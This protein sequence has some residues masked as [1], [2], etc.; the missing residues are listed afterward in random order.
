MA[1]QIIYGEE[2]RKALKSGVDQLAD[3]V[4]LTL[5]PRGRNVVLEKPFGS[6]LITNDG[7]TIA[8]DIELEDVFENMGAQIA[9]EV[10]V[11]TN[12]VA[13]DGTTTAAVLVQAIVSE[14]IKN[15]T[16]G[17]NP[18]LLRKGILDTATIAVEELKAISKPVVDKNDIASVAAISADDQEIG[19]LVS[20]AMEKVGKD[21]VIS[22]QEGQSLSTTLDVVEGMQ[23]DRGYV[24]GYMA[25]N[26]SKMI[27]EL[28]SPAILITDRKISTIQELLPIIEQ[29]VK[30]GLKLVII[31]DDFEQEVTATLVL[32][33]LKGV[34]NCVAVKAPGFGGRR[35]EMLEDIA[36]LTNGQ[37]ISEDI[38]LEVKDATINM[39]GRAKLVTVD[40]DNTTIIGGAGSQKDIE[41]RIAG[42]KEQIKNTTSSYDKE[43]LQERLAKLAGGVA[44][45]NVGAAT[46]IE[47]QEKKHRI[48][49][50]LA[51]TKAAV[52]E[53]TVPGGGV[54]LLT[55][56]ENV[57]K[58]TEKF[59]DDYK[60]GANAVIK[61][62]EAPMRQIA[63][64]SGV[65]G[66]VVINTI[67]SQ[68]SK[69]FGYDALNDKY[70]D[71]VKEGIIDPTKVTRTALQNAA[72]IAASLLTTESLVADIPQPPGAGMPPMPQDAGMY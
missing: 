34:F 70:V 50:A 17:A 41:A 37:V 51:A 3:T 11:K 6:P 72:S 12:E 31:A 19:V 33:K 39:L 18:M 69:T 59:E 13:G 15:V 24:S 65:D 61:A 4:K 47:M 68:D 35:K 25:T 52:E 49:D 36:V 53:G 45:I 14:G 67:K 5:G 71:M 22:V 62:L 28:D 16:A 64:N 2:A 43:K 38:G 26:L 42:I 48:E 29:V 57:K 10:S 1:K 58:A 44:V 30:S 7:V 9:K 23:F 54:A 20:E 46:E 60:T 63:I 40:K 21:G 32:N 27:A 8:R 56:S 66:G 55:I